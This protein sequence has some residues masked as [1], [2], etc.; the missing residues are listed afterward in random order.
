MILYLSDEE[1][2]EELNGL[3]ADI[4]IMIF[5]HQDMTQIF[6]KELQHMGAVT[7][8][9]IEEQAVDRKTWD[10]AAE[11]FRLSQSVPLLLLVDE[12]ETPETFIRGENYDILNRSHRDISELLYTWIQNVQTDSVDG[13]RNTSSNMDA[14]FNQVWIAAAGLTTGA[15][16]TALAMHLAAYIH[17]QNQEVA[18]TE[19]ADAFARLA[20]V[21]EWNEL[22]EGSYQWGGIIYNHNQID[23]NIPYTVFDLALM[24][25]RCHE[26]WK[27]CQIKILVVDGKPY[28]MQDLTQQLNTLKDYPGSIILAFTFVPEAERAALRNQYASEQVKV[29]FVPFEPDLFTF[30]DDYQELVEGYV[31]PLPKEEKKRIVIPFHLPKAALL[32]PKSRQ[33]QL[34]QKQKIVGLFLCMLLGAF[35]FGMAVTHKQNDNIQVAVDSVSRMDFTGITRIR[36]LLVS[37]QAAGTEMLQGEDTG[38]SETAENEIAEAN[39]DEQNG[40][41]EN[42][43]ENTA[44]T[45]DGKTQTG[46]ETRTATEAPATE[47]AEEATEETTAESTQAPQTVPA[48]VTQSLG[49]YHGQIYT[50]S[51]VVTIMNQMSG[52]LV[53]I[54]LVTRSSDGWYNYSVSES[55]FAAAASVSA[56]ISMIDTQ[57]SFLCQVIQVNGE[58]AGLAFVQQ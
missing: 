19:R 36:M 15:G 25:S 47:D 27:K 17:K 2:E 44:G 29:W 9:I 45:G 5:Q 28:H 7:H 18:V 20:E 13:D 1:H 40:A 53:A 51:D 11:A 24:N 50:G 22:A 23:E 57:C 52:Q 46:K 58:D 56:G 10:T 26:I 42:G 6:R 34:T 14:A 30:S 31:K 21:Y 4:H 41:W 39:P 12:P 54:H 8:I 38:T 48:A 55:G 49:G 43:T 16:T 32:K 3:N 33:R 37:E 35:G